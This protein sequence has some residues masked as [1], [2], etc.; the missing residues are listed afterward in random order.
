MRR[1]DTIKPLI[2][3]L[4]ACAVGLVITFF[5]L[6]L[7]YSEARLQ[8]ALT[9]RYSA[10]DL[11]IWAG[12]GKVDNESLVID[13]LQ[14]D[15]FSFVNIGWLHIDTR[16]Y[17]NI[18]ISF[19]E[20]HPNQPLLLA[21]K[22]SGKE[23]PVE[24]SIL[25]TNDMTSRFFISDLVA[26]DSIITE[27]G[28]V[29][30]KLINPYRIQSIAFFPKKLSHTAFVYLLMDCFAINQQW[31]NWSIN[32]HKSPYPVFIPPKILVLIYFTV[33]GLLFLLY[34]RLTGRPLINAWWATLVAA[35]FA[36][37]AHYLVEKTVI[38]KNTYETFAHLSDDE[39][40]LILSPE[41]AKL[42]QTIQS[43]L[44]DD[45]QRKKIRIQFGW[46]EAWLSFKLSEKRYLSG[47]L[48]Y[49]LYPNTIYTRGKKIPQKTWQQGKFYYVD[50]R[51][52]EYRLKYDI[53]SNEL[54]TEQQIKISAK[55]LLDNDEITIYQV[56]GEKKQ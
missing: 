45:G 27:V 52:R 21:V 32:T 12:Q 48:Q 39:K 22:L 7:Y 14:P 9:Q 55:Q 42:A 11:H 15:G 24:R 2:A 36:L 19:A 23:R 51:E 35:W 5:G 56:L 20:K 47:K 30:D 38:T 13:G 16:F 37:D 33:V 49:Y 29:T 1:N 50:A 25:Y 4:L 6:R 17:E 3:F 18:V 28:L 40:D 34:L 10:K 41:A 26:K 44:P 43:V 31:E 54:I 46:K 53:E 8:K